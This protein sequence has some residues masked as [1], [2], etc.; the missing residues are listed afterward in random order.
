MDKTQMRIYELLDNY[1]HYCKTNG[2]SDFKIWC[3][4]CNC[5]IEDKNLIDRI[6]EEVNYIADK[7][8]E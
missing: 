7:L 1:L 8:F 4:E 6:S 2:Y 5:T 3:K